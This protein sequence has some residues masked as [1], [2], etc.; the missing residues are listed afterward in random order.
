MFYTNLNHRFKT[1]PPKSVVKNDYALDRWIK[2]QEAEE[3]SERAKGST[4][5]KKKRGPRDGKDEFNSS[6]IIQ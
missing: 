3:R 5:T 6:Q 1:P 2:T 4:G